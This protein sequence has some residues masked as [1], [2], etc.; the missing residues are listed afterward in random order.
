MSEDTFAVYGKSFQE[1]VVQALIT[2]HAW[3]EQM[4]EVFNPEYL[5]L[6][7]LQFLARAYFEHAKKYRVFPT[8]QL[9]ITIIRD[10]LKKGSDKILA[11]QIVEYLTR[12]KANPDVGDLSY[13][14]DKSLDFC[15]KQALK[16]AMEDAIDLMAT[17]KY[18]A[19]VDVMKKAVVV[20][21]TPSLGHE[22]FD[23]ACRES[24]FIEQSR[25]AVATGIPELDHRDILNGGLGM[26]ELGICI[27]NTGVGKSHMLVQIGAA[28][29]RLGIDVVHYTC[30]LSEHI[31]GKRYDSHLAKVDFSDLIDFKEHVVKY[32]DDNQ[33]LGRL[34]I[35]H[36]P[37]GFP[38]AYTL[39]SHIER[40]AT[41]EFKPGLMIIDSLD[42]MRSTRQLEAL[43]L[44]LKHVYEEVRAYV[45]ELRIPC[46]SVSQS[47]KEGS[48]NDIVDLTNMSEAYGKAMVADVVISISRKSHEKASGF[49]R[50]YMAKNRAGRDGLVW[51]V[52]IDTAQSRFTI[53]GYA[54]TAEEETQKD[55]NQMKRQI[56]S[57]L[58]ELEQDPSLSVKKPS[59]DDQSGS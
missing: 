37:V 18:D 45:D 34:I 40:A 35:K 39:R 54:N 44:E 21:T 43:R 11:D 30:E 13:V 9:L 36:Y 17:E 26:G 31:I 23:E 32:Y 16:K 4:L 42:N 28:A 10:K 27:A 19:I 50:I 41:R 15:R 14:K 12:M 1:K 33:D 51:P 53:A 7:Y 5:E 6:K 47:N 2:D 56:R 25:N 24:R 58:R 29:L 22:F 8:M 3:G 48:N 38:T 20:G 52:K 57:K 55:E 59:E 46:W 49:G